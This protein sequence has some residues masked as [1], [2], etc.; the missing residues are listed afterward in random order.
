MGASPQTPQASLRSKVT[1]LLAETP[2]TSN[3][4]GR[5]NFTILFIHLESKESHFYLCRAEIC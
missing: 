3:D 5:R 1:R 4:S 2:G